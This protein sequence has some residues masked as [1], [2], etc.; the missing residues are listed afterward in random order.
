[1]GY[2]SS[3]KWGYWGPVA[4]SLIRGIH[5]KQYQHASTVHF[6][7]RTSL[8]SNTGPGQQQSAKPHDSAYC[9]PVWFLVGKD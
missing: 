7:S 6:E 9:C 1:V 5:T 8:F 2:W 4:H 3:S